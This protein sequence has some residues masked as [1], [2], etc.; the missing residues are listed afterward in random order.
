MIVH[1]VPS[2]DFVHRVLVPCLRGTT[3]FDNHSMFQC[4]KHGLTLQLTK[5]VALPFLIMDISSNTL[6]ISV[7]QIVWISASQRQLPF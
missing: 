4:L 2:S 7:A 6:L 1:S 3:P 5:G